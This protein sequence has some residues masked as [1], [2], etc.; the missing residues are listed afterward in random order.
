MTTVFEL[1]ARCIDDRFSPPG[2][3]PEWTVQGDLALLEW[4]SLGSMRWERNPEKS[5]TTLLVLLPPPFLPL[6]EQLHAEGWRRGD[7]HLPGLQGWKV[8]VYRREGDA[9][10]RIECAIYGR[11]FPDK[12]PNQ[13]FFGDPIP[14]FPDAERGT[15]EYEAW[16]AAVEEW[17]RKWREDEW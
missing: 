7:R 4:A 13:P 12:S 16:T 10:V 2:Y 11:D 14:P 1:M 17:Y 6:V 9:E 3:D 8:I 5:G 15:P